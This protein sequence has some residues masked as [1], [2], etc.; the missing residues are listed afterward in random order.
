MAYRNTEPVQCWLF[1]HFESKVMHDEVA[2]RLR[3]WTANP[4]G[5]PRNQFFRILHFSADERTRTV[6]KAVDIK[7]FISVVEKRVYKIL[8]Q[9]IHYLAQEDATMSDRKKRF[10]CVV[11]AEDE[12]NLRPKS[13]SLKNVFLSRHCLHRQVQLKRQLAKNLEKTKELTTLTLLSFGL[14]GD[15]PEAVGKHFIS[16]SVSSEPRLKTESSLDGAIPIFNIWYWKK[17]VHDEVAEWLRRWTAN[18]LGFPRHYITKRLLPLEVTSDLNFLLKPSNLKPHL[19]SQSIHTGIAGMNG[20]AR[21]ALGQFKEGEVPSLKD[22]GGPN[23]QRF[24]QSR[25]VTVNKKKGTARVPSSEEKCTKQSVNRILGVAAFMVLSHTTPQAYSADTCGA[26]C[27]W[28]L[29]YY[30][31]ENVAKPMVIALKTLM[32]GLGV[33]RKL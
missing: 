12:S 5:F 29:N 6:P 13:S 1:T 21:T 14:I 33:L 28:A 15:M 25:V 26:K 23:R 11:T 10:S 16:R 27:D 32:A 20:S 17:V 30:Y 9:S 8:W 3:R 19:K 7:H 2:E 22:P 24:N 31:A 18:P 4:L